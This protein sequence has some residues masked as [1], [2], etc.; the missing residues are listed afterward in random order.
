[1]KR[2]HLLIV[3]ILLPLLTSFWAEVRA[4]SPETRVRIV[5]DALEMMPETLRTVLETHD[6]A[7]RRGALEPLTEEGTAAHRPPWDGGTLAEEVAR[8]ADAL[9]A[10]V[11]GQESFEVIAERFGAL[12]HF[13]SDAGFPPVAGGG[14]DD[15]RYRHFT[16]LVRDRLE[17]IPFVFY[18]HGDPDLDRSSPEGYVLAILARARDEDLVLARAYR[19]AGE[20]PAPSAFDDRSIPFAIASLSYSR[21]VTDV[22]RVWLHAWG[23]AHGDMGRTPYLKSPSTY[24]RP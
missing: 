8:R 17:K 3:A 22:V 14:D 4:W 9:V 21:C 12:A 7:L 18:G 5:E 10:A 23:R 16:N 11:D 20:N 2:S 6:K 1:M 15:A 24:R 19:A 13:V